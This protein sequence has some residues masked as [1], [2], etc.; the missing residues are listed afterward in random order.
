LRDISVRKR[1]EERIRYLAAY[2]TLTGL[3]NRNTLYEQLDSKL[4]TTKTEQCEVALLMLDLDKFKD[5]N[6]TL[7]HACGDEVLCAVAGRLNDLVGK[8]GVVAD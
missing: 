3:P 4:G 5:I 7:G 6:D 2:D 8:T 1:E